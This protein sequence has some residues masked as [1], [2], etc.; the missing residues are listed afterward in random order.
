VAVAP[1]VASTGA[2]RLRPFPPPT[3]MRLA[4]YRRDGTATY[5]VVEGTTVSD[6]VAAGGPGSLRLALGS[7]PDGLAAL[8]AGDA[9]RVALDDVDLLPVVP[10]PAKIVCVGINY[11]DHRTETNRPVVDHPTL[12]TRFADTQVAHG[13]PAIKPTVSDMLDYEGELAVVIGAPCWQVAPA[14]ALGVVAGYSCY[15]DFSVRDWQRHTSQFTPGKNFPRT[16]GFGPWLVTADEIADP[17]GLTLTT[18]VNGEVRQ[19][20]GVSDLIFD[21]PALIAYITTFTALAPGDVIVTGTPGGVGQF[22]EPPTFLDPGD[23]VEVEITSI[24]TLVNPIA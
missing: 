22:R 18:R 19:H 6:L 16:G 3:S 12:F 15:N 20:A 4:S 7:G 1:S 21:V 14:D 5:G 24:G 2:L 13:H 9:P 17:A 10:D 11:V 8:T 23:V